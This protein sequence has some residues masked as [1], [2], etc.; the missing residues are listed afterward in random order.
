MLLNSKG[1]KKEKNIV[2]L[3]NQPNNNKGINT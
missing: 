3:E 2:V 1:S